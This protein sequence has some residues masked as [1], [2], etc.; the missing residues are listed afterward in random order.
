MS[1]SIPIKSSTYSCI[2]STP[3]LYFEFILSEPFAL[4]LFFP[5]KVSLGIDNIDA[6]SEELRRSQNGSIMPTSHG[7]Y[8]DRAVNSLSME[9]NLGVPIELSNSNA[10]RVVYYLYE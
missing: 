8:L 5:I 10:V 6:F 2:T 7:D 1:I 9:M 4:F 3:F